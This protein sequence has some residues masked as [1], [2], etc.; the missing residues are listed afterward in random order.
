MECGVS[1]LERAGPRQPRT[2]DKK[3][4]STQKH[5]VR[6]R[7]KPTSEKETTAATYFCD[8]PRSP[9]ASRSYRD[10]TS[11]PRFDLKLHRMRPSIYHMAFDRSAETRRAV[12]F[13]KARTSFN[14]IFQRILRFK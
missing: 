3:P 9:R 8:E 12:T 6:E 5:P 11:I 1:R 7:D 2:A 4:A 13:K 14:N 10:T